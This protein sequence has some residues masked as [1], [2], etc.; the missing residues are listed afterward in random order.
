MLPAKDP[1]GGQIT[2]DGLA[3]KASIDTPYSVQ[4][5]DE[6]GQDLLGG[7]EHSSDIRQMVFGWKILD[8]FD[9]ELSATAFDIEQ[10]IRI[11]GLEL[12]GPIKLNIRDMHDNVSPAATAVLIFDSEKPEPIS[13]RREGET[14]ALA[15]GQTIKLTRAPG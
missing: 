12:K 5:L 11:P 2:Y 9:F 1:E 3:F 4:L 15:N 14:A 10:T 8:D 13:I 7:A 6:T